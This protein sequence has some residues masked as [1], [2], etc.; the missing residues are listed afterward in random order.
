MT[1]V[2]TLLHKG[3]RNGFSEE[4]LMIQPCT[5][6]IYKKYKGPYSRK[7]SD[8]SN[9]LRKNK[10]RMSS[11]KYNKLSLWISGISFCE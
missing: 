2:M 7:S 3:L 1:E 4:S 5:E 10:N 9:I 8:A 6:I 11:S